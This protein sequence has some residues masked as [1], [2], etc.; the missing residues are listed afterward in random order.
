MEAW[1]IANRPG[2]PRVVAAFYCALETDG[3]GRAGAYIRDYYG[4]LGSRAEAMVNALPLTAEAIRDKINSYAA[5]GVDELILWPC[6]SDPDQVDGLA[7]IVQ[8]LVG[9]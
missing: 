5:A 6:I 1:H 9:L 3:A 8:S 7:R 2:K 4:F